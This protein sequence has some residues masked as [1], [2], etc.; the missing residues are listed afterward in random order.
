MFYIPYPLYFY[1]LLLPIHP[2]PTPHFPCLLCIFFLFPFFSFSCKLEIHSVSHIIYKYVG[3]KSNK[4]NEKSIN[5]Q[6]FM[7]W[8]I[9]YRFSNACKLISSIIDRNNFLFWWIKS[10]SLA[11]TRK[12]KIWMNEWERK[13]RDIKKKKKY[14]NKREIKNWN[15]FVEV[16]ERLWCCCPSQKCFRIFMKNKKQFHYFS[17]N[18]TKFEGFKE[19]KI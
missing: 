17:G 3:C 12:R 10:S 16:T 2:T 18:W 4:A 6:H 13:R 9:S 11:H 19:F 14:E 7:R 8:N 5:F 15:L 1:F